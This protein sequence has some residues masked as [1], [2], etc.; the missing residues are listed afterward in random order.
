MAGS[1]LVANS[2][3]LTVPRED[4]SPTSASFNFGAL[5]ERSVVGFLGGIFSYRENNIR[6]RVADRNLI[7][8]NVT[9]KMIKLTHTSSSH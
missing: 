2:N 3:C 1:A 8:K 6:H 4:P 9:V 7:Y 5:G